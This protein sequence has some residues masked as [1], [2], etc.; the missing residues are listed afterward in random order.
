MENEVVV[1]G[2]INMDLVMDVKQRP[3][4][5][6][7]TMGESFFTNP[8]GKGA[9]QAFSAAT[10]GGNVTMLG[11][12]GDDLF[13]EQ[14]L[15]NLKNIGVNT[16][17]IQKIDGETSGI[18]MITVD[19]NGENSI[20]VAP[21][22]NNKVTPQYITLHEHV[23][24]RAKAILIQLEIP[25]ESV[26][27][28]IEIAKKY[29]VP[30]LL[31][32]AP[33][34]ELPDHMLTKIDYILPNETEL[35]QLTNRKIVDQK[36]AI[37]ASQLLISK[38]VKTVISKLGKDGVIICQNDR[39]EWIKGYDVHA[40]DTTGAGD[41]FAGAFATKLVAGLDVKSS[42]KYANAVGAL[43]VT[44]KGAQSAMPNKEDVQVYIQSQS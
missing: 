39:A 21:A 27:K 28:S 16:E 44:K 3:A 2:S 23:I 4:G 13:G 29:H 32:P 34:Q 8:G 31:D 15:I 41:A 38:G 35:E 14:L 43:T 20:I 12:V 25:F 36:T 11:C 9:N 26:E 1:I 37:Q 30:V 22:A 42:A 40:I 17:Y 33:A 6:E 24:K 7:T 19:Q 10:I 18:A 5:G